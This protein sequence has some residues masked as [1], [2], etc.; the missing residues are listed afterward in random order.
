L[1]TVLSLLFIFPQQVFAEGIV[2]NNQCNEQ[3][4]L[5]RRNLVLALLKIEECAQIYQQDSAIEDPTNLISRTACNAALSFAAAATASVGGILAASR[6]ERFRR[7][8][9]RALNAVGR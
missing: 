9:S 8:G 2:T 6:I 1:I 4:L 7:L 3:G 5:S